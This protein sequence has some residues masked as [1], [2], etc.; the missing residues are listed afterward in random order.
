ML[1]TVNTS[2]NS[3][4]TPSASAPLQQLGSAVK[5]VK[6]CIVMI[7][8][9]TAHLMDGFDLL[10]YD[11]ESVELISRILTHLTAIMMYSSSLTLGKLQQSCL[12]LLNTLIDWQNRS[13]K[14]WHI[15]FMTLYVTQQKTF[16]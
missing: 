7:V 15:Q 4:L 2:L 6:D 3:C 8:K 13:V 14:R 1:A 5:I 16:L 12:E 9:I 10:K 11:K